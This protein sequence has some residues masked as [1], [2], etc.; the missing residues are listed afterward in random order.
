MSA[1]IDQMLIRFLEDNFVEDLLK[2]QLGLSTLFN[3]TYE[4]DD[5]EL[6]EIDFAGTKSRQFQMPAF[7]TIRTTGT[8]ER[9]M[10]TQERIK[11]NHEQSRLG[12]LSWIEVYLEVL[13]LTKVHSKEAPIEKIT[14][15][16]LLTKIGGADS[17]D[18]LKNKL[19]TL[20]PDSV[21]EAFFKKFRITKFEDF[22]RRGNRFL[23]FVYKAPPPYDP[24]DPQ[25]VRRFKVNICV[26]FQP[27]L[28]IAET[29]QDAKL[30]R[31]IL[32]NE[33]N[34]AET[35]EGGEVKMPYIFLVIFPDGVIE[36]NSIP[37]MSAEQIKSS[38]TELF[39]VENMVVHFFA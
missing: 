28:K 36:D 22:K 32:E 35:F 20:Y 7:E 24:D 23:E 29:L 15:R 21:V 31:S 26:K 9:L 33:K 38:I 30:C 10:P 25:N 2:N 16:D 4:T 18:E 19:R 1:F 5:I 8:E 14:T 27:E 12:R 39:S 17:I 13:L 37:G 11:V 34:F 6:K 3:L